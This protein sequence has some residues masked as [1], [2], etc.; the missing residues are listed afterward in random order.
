M[1]IKD[2]FKGIALLSL[3]LL[4]SCNDFLDKLPDNRTDI[5]TQEKVMK[6]LVSAYATS[7]SAAMHE[8]MSDNVS[9]AGSSIDVGL[10][11][12]SE[13][14]QFRNITSQSQDS[15]YATWENNYS[16]ISSANEALQA[17]SEIE[18]TGG[19][20]LHALKGEALLCRAYAH[21]CLVNTFCQPYN[22]Q[23][24]E[25]DLGVPYVEVVETTAFNKYERGTVAQVYA[26]INEDIEAGLP[27]IDDNQYKQ[28][29]YH[30]NKKA[31]YAFAA[32]FNLYYGEYQKAKDY[33]TSA[34]GANP[35]TGLR[36]YGNWGKY[37]S[38]AEYSADW[39]NSD[40]ATNYLIQPLTSYAG[41]YYYYRFVLTYSLLSKTL[42]S[43]GPWSER[44][45]FGQYIFSNNSRSYY[46]PKLAYYFEYTDQASGIGFYHAVPVPFTTERT[47]IDRAEASAMLGRY[48]ETASDLSSFYKSS[49]ALSS[50]SSSEIESFYSSYENND[51]LNPRFELIPGTQTTFIHACL[52]ARRILT[53]HEGT[54]TL[55]LKR[56]G[57]PYVHEIINGATIRIEPFDKR[58]AIQIPEKVIAAGIES[59]PR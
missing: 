50:V 52:H 40:Q 14:Y 44:L 30:F 58:L 13:S 28:P 17:I 46:F 35:E 51:E 8:L 33:A 59:N 56:F 9:D 3:L 37:T 41:T 31:A 39:I 10:D 48:D 4:V 57:I 25:V 34:L 38:F 7:T 19:D 5:D 32:Q 23:T 43:D 55:D 49:G 47:L 15:P 27:L 11:V 54:R 12:F 45:I 18:Q 36:N 16:A 24:S 21:F 22:K 1:K 29:K 2:I 26:K 53:V 6:I 20:Y 42:L